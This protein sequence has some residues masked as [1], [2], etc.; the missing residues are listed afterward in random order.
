MKFLG[1][2]NED[3]YSY[4]EIAGILRRHCAPFLAEMKRTGIIPHDNPIN[5]FIYRGIQG[6]FNGEIQLRKVRQFR[7]PT[8]TPKEVHKYID[9]L[10]FMHYGWKARSQGVFC[11]SKNMAN[12]YGWAYVFVP[13]GKYEYLWS[14]FVADL[15]G[16]LLDMNYITRDGKILDL[17][18]NDREEL[19]EMIKTAY[20]DSQI[21]KFMKMFQEH[22][23]MFKCKEYYLIKP[24][25]A[26][27]A[28][29]K[30]FKR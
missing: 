24:T 21:D 11:A 17:F 4:E 27:A 5:W 20:K 16:T 10:F 14:P 9:K 18:Y 19:D 7:N 1:F 8:D 12:T 3:R 23:I 13:V 6:N 22:E 26:Q 29:E 25:A 15:F 30:I 28:Y 2:L